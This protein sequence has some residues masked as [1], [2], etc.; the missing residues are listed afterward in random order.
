MEH[1][2]PTPVSPGGTV[3]W[4][5]EGRGSVEADTGKPDVDICKLTHVMRFSEYIFDMPIFCKCICMCCA[6]DICACAHHVRENGLNVGQYDWDYDP[7]GMNFLS[8]GGFAY[9][10]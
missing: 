8:N 4:S 2:H 6:L 9:A 5:W 1:G 10:T 3:Q 7:Q